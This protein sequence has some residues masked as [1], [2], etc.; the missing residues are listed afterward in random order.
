[1]LFTGTAKAGST[2]TAPTDTVIENYYY[3]A[4]HENNVNTGK[5]SIDAVTHLHMY[6]NR[7]VHDYTVQYLEAGTN[8]ELAEEKVVYD[9][10]WGTIAT[11]LADDENVAVN[12]DIYQ[13]YGDAEKSLEISVDETENVITF[14]YTEKRVT[15]N[16]AVVGPDG[17]VNL[18]GTADFGKVEPNSESLQILSGKASGAK[19]TA[20]PAYKFVGWYDN[21]KCEGDVLSTEATFVPTKKDGELWDDGTTYYAKF[22]YNLTSLTIVKD[23]AEEYKDIDPNQSFIF[24]IYDGDTPVTTVTVN[25]TTGLRV[26]VDGLTVGKQYKV[27]EKTD[28]SWRYHCTGWEYTGSNATVTGAGNEASI[29]LGLD[30]TITFTNTRGNE[31]W[32]DGDSWCNNIFGVPKG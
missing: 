5:V 23:G 30:G 24:D 10:K 1:M 21:A 2:V 8:K 6:Y 31:Q 9:L 25:S 22:E 17:T 26:V 14:Y 27:I 15:L 19:A 3:Y 11:E 20:E 28:W 7:T 16:Y 32:L 29:T 12:F 4:A 18:D 13:V